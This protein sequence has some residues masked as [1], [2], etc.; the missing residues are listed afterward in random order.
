MTFKLK[1]QAFRE[2]DTIPTRHTCDGEDLSPALSWEDA[3][4]T[5]RS[6]ALIVDDPDAP[7]GTWTHW[8]LWD[9]PPSATRIGEGFRPGSLGAGGT[10]DFRQAGY[11]GPCPPRGHGSHRYYFKLFALD[12]ATLGLREG[13]RRAEVDRALFGHVLADARYMGRYERRK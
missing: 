3:P 13:A 12:V 7:A 4:P 8:L 6:F 1:V 5:T 2:G 9:I 10:N 11:G